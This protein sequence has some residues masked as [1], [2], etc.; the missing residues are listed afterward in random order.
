MST[1]TDLHRAVQTTLASQRLG[2]PVFVRYCLHRL[3]KV[4][5]PLPA[6]AQV[7]AVV[8]DWLGQPLDRVY[9]VGTLESGQVSLTLQFREGATALVSYA[10]G[11]L[12]GE[13]VD[14]LVLGNRG[15]LS[16]DAGS[17]APWDEVMPLGRE[18]PDPVL[19]ALIEKALRSGKPEAVAPE[20]NR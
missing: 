19:Q 14:L 7:T 8:R 16:H 10:R 18:R 4:E 13:G 15:A 5:A 12:R 20:A 2:K 11:T 17:E 9:A 6:L 3:G 1:L